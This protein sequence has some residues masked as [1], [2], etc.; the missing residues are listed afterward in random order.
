MTPRPRW[1]SADREPAAGRWPEPR[2]ALDLPA[3]GSVLEQ[4]LL[5]IGGWVLF[6]S[7][8]TARID[9][10]LGEHHLGRARLGLHR[11]DVRLVS[12]NPLGRFAGFELI[13]DLA[14]LPIKEGESSIRIAAADFE[15]R[16][17]DLNPLPIRISPPGPTREKR[18]AHPPHGRGPGETGRLRM[19]ISTHQL[20]LGGAQLQLLELLSGLLELGVVEPLVLTTGDGPLRA[21]LERLGVPI[22]LCGPVPLDDVTLHLERVGELVGW[23]RERRFEIALI[24]TWTSHSLPGAEVA[25]ALGIPAVWLIHE[26]FE[27]AELLEACVPTVRGRAEQTLAQASL[28]IFENDATR[29][30][31]EPLIP[32]GRTRT[33]PY[34]IDLEAIEARRAGFDRS[35]A[36][37]REGIPQNAEVIVCVGAIEPRKGQVPLVLAFE[38]IA[39]LYPRARLALIGAR[40][41]EHT[42]FLEEVV[43]DLDV[44][45]RVRVVPFT[46]DVDH[47]LGLSDLLVCASDVESLPRVV[48]EA[49]A[50]GTPVLATRIFGLPDVIED[51][52]SGW[53]CPERDS[54]ALASALDRV[55]ST[56][57]AQR[58]R[59]GHAGRELCVERHRLEAY[60]D[61]MAALLQRIARPGAA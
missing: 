33:L 56:E 46:S 26:S 21:P 5:R 45:A 52:V 25:G 30:L 6:P 7:G 57:P 59:V 18:W 2:G 24:N 10:W 19:L 35:S 34:G 48:L 15:G 14:K 51:G 53:L 49:M 31:F 44:P 42:R 17:L 4:G 40:A 50:W 41:D 39:P 28:A 29:A 3:S 23:A 60:V 9:V 55:L 22:Q 37:R 32:S 54:G 12:Q 20:D 47:W 38:R 43:A 36:R 16:R 8:P 58:R 13:T 27:P 1:R 11:E 61:Q